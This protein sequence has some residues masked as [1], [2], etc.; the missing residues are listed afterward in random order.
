MNIVKKIKKVE[1]E[2]APKT[3]YDDIYT[4]KRFTK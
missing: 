1:F 3:I 2:N 4:I